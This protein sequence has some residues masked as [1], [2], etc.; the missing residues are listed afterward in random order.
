MTPYEAY[1]EE[2]P[3][4]NH[5]RVFGCICYAHI[6]KDE[7][8]KLDSKAREAIMLGYGTEVKGYRLYNPNSQKI[9]F[10]RD[11]IFNESRMYNELK[12][13]KPVNKVEKLINIEDENYKTQ[14]TEEKGEDLINIEDENEVNNTEKDSYVDQLNDCLPDAERKSVRNRKAP[15]Y[16]GEWA[17]TANKIAQEPNT[18]KEALSSHNSEKWIDA[19]KD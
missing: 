9:F 4:V 17:N 19:M 5:L 1:T 7:R 15:E 8:K 13:I 16:Y 12:L 2:K 10:S 3:N 6:P 18:F 11:V 14:N